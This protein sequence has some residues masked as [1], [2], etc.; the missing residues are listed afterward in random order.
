MSI[1][2]DGISST[3]L[4]WEIAGRPDSWTRGA[5][6]DGAQIQGGGWGDIWNAENWFH[7][8]GTDGCII[9]CSNGEGAG[10]YSFHS[11]GVNFLLCDG[12]ARFLSENVSA[13]VFVS[14]VS[15]DGGVDV[16]DY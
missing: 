4:M 8:I 9:N 14:L 10:A 5:K 7:G 16:G 6:L 11:G 3:A 1:I 13:T 15:L 2:R 12:S